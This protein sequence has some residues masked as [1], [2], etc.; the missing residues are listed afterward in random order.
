MKKFKFKLEDIQDKIKEFR[1][2]GKRWHEYNKHKH[3]Q[4]IYNEYRN[5]IVF[6]N[7]GDEEFFIKNN[8]DDCFPMCDLKLSYSDDEIITQ[9]TIRGHTVN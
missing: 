5:K 7:D 2:Q 8:I 4:L 1:E 3:Q 6:T 9:I